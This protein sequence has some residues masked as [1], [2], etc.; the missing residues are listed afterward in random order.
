MGLLFTDGTLAITVKVKKITKIFRKIPNCGD[1]EL[2][3]EME[4]YSDWVGLWEFGGGFAA[5]VEFA[6]QCFAVENCEKP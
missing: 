6:Q 2:D 1:G 4:W 3:A 5:S